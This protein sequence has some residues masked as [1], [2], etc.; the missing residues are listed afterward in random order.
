MAKKWLAIA[1]SNI[2]LIKYMGKTEAA[3]N[4]PT[5]AS[6]SYTLPHLRSIVEI[7]AIDSGEDRWEPLPSFEGRALTP[8]QLSDKG[9]SR[10]LAHLGR[11]KT[12]FDYQGSFVVRSANDFPSDCGLASSA[13]S[14]AALTMG[15][16]EA[17]AALTGM[18][19]PSRTDAA[20]LSRQGSGSSCR[21]FFAPWSIWDDDG[22][23]EAND[24]GHANLIHQTIVVDEAVKSVSSS[25]AHLRVATSANFKGRPERANQRLKDLVQALRGDEW[26]NAFEITWAE[27]WDMHA[28]FE[29]A[30]PS[31]GYMTPGSLEALR[32]VRSLTWEK[33]GA[34][35]LVTMDAG[36]NLHL[37]YRSNEAA[38]AQ[39]V[40][41]TLQK[42]FMVISS[43][44]K[45]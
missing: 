24:L 38:L 4:R 39:D 1:P 25:S 15:S 11:L 29:T 28:L 43:G 16:L 21:S 33:T 17:L 5:N 20:D 30:N 22:A 31:F 23:R 13:S 36:P 10:F 45:P 19:A 40:A 44:Q 34:G 37:L 27:F 32:T 6:L 14:F 35:P 42:R 18:P 3:A 7:E 2:A 26:T 41:A 8:I 9:R 12:K